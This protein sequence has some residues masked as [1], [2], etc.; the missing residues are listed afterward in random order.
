MCDDSGNNAISMPDNN[1]EYDTV[2]V[3]EPMTEEP[4]VMV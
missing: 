2:R 1:R 4:P 3:S